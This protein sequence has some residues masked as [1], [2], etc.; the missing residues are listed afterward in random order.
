MCKCSL[1]VA[2]DKISC[3]IDMNVCCILLY[4]IEWLKCLQVLDE[5]IASPAELAK[6]YMG[7]RPSKV[8]PSM[9]GISSQSE[10]SNM[11]GNRIPPKTPIMSLVPRSSSRVQVSENGF[12]TPRYR[13]R[14]ALYNMARTPYSRDGLTATTRVRLFEHNH[15]CLELHISFVG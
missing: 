9:A 10:A 15:S 3:N 2:H 7:S 12:T 13:G 11:F 1:L 4:D 14:S 8:S 5:D 6:A